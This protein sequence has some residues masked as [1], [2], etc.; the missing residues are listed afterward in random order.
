MGYYCCEEKAM[1]LIMLE[2]LAIHLVKY[3]PELF[4]AMKAWFDKENL[5]FKLPNEIIKSSHQI[6]TLISS[7]LVPF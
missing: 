6:Q 5:N 7:L 3:V 1:P 4:V 2:T